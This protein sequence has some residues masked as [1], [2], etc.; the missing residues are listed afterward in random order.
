MVCN[1]FSHENLLSRT[2]EMTSGIRL[3]QESRGGVAADRQEDLITHGLRI[4]PTRNSCDL[5]AIGDLLA[6]DG[7]T[8]TAASP[9]ARR[10]CGRGGAGG[11]PSSGRRLRA[12]HGLTRRRRGLRRRRKL[13]SSRMDVVAGMLFSNVVMFAIIVATAA[14]LHAHGKTTLNSAADT[15]KTLEPL[16][17]RW[18]GALFALGFIGSGMLAIPVLAGSGAAGLAGLLGQRSGFSRSVRKAPTFYGLVALGTLGGT[19]LTLP[20]VNPVPPHSAGSPLH[21]WQLA[22]L[23][24]S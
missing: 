2:N 10:R 8:E 4:F 3:S 1:G 19:A 15:A 21:S 17:G 23:P 20:H 11:L 12:I 16:A 22:Q 18:A 14:T 9:E 5:S 24:A 13:L 6:D 7:R